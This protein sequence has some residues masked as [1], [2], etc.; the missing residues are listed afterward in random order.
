[1]KKQQTRVTLFRLYSVL[2]DYDIIKITFRCLSVEQL[3]L[4]SKQSVSYKYARAYTMAM[5]FLIGT[6]E[7]D[8]TQGKKTVLLFYLFHFIAEGEKKIWFRS[9]LSI[10]KKYASGY[11]IRK[12]FVV[13]CLQE[14][15]SGVCWLYERKQKRQKVS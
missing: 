7:L 12:R 8:W 4:A 14:Y 2:R 6:I 1:M 11:L 13:I 3:R 10:L 9:D 15:I 5:A